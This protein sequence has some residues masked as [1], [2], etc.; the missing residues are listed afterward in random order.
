MLAL[1][2]LVFG[3]VITLYLKPKISADKTAETVTTKTRTKKKSSRT[4]QQ[5]LNAQVKNIS[6]TWKKNNELEPS[7]Q[8][9]YEEFATQDLDRVKE[10]VD[11]Y[12]RGGELISEDCKKAVAKSGPLFSNIEKV[13]HPETGVQ[14][15]CESLMAF[16]R[17]KAITNMV[18]K[19]LPLDRW[20]ES[21]LMNSVFWNFVKN[22]EQPSLTSLQENQK[23]LDQLILTSP[24][25]YAV[26][27]ASFVHLLLEQLIYKKMDKDEALDEA[28]ERLTGF[29]E[30]ESDV[31][32]FPLLKPMLQN[33]MVAF[34]EAANQWI[35]ENPEDPAGY[36]AKAQIAWK[37]NN[38]D[39]TIRQLEE[40]VRLNPTDPS[41]QDT[42]AKARSG[43]FDDKIFLISFGF[44]FD[45]I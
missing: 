17:A 14:K 43:K 11:D 6:T 38:R 27:K 36:Y 7:C 4:F 9:S 18:D 34:E 13:C 32:R 2:S 39:E 20:T 3:A 40:A 25:S 28:Y 8:E 31:Q 16:M 41:Y 19:T 35:E 22:P 44:N 21:E 30:V 37:A 42:L 26:N 12:F 29:D 24:D 10:M 1:L 45:Q 5:A 23:Y 33:D 15:E